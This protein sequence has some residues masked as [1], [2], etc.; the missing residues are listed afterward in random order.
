MFFSKSHPCITSLISFHFSLTLLPFPFFSAST[1]ST[2]SHFSPLLALWMH[3]NLPLL[4]R[5]WVILICLDVLL[6]SPKLFL[7]CQL[8]PFVSEL[9]NPCNFI[10]VSCTSGTCAHSWN[11]INLWHLAWCLPLVFFS[12]FFAASPLGRSCSSLALLLDS[13]ICLYFLYLL[14]TWTPSPPSYIIN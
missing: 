9:S 10:L 3:R 13:P 7:I 6:F 2:F 4:F 8:L 5:L 14:K 1:D 11:V 12:S